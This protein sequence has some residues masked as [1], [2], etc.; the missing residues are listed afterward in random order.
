V[1]PGSNILR[2]HILAGMAGLKVD[3]DVIIDQLRAIDNRRLVRKIGTIQ[4]TLAQLVNAN[5]RVVLRL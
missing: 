5:L 2:V 1:Q 3:S 4:A